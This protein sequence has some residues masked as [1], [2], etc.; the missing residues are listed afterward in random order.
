MSSLNGWLARLTA[1]L[2]LFVSAVVVRALP[3]PTVITEKT[4]IQPFGNDAHY[5]LRRIQYAALNPGDFLSRDSYVNFPYG[6]TPI[7]PPTFDW[8]LARLVQLTTGAGDQAAM[9]RLLVCV[10]P[11]L[12]G[13]TVVALYWIA[14][15]HFSSAVARHR[16]FRL[17][18]PPVFQ[19]S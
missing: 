17:V 10:P 4:G 13:C 12:G 1:P 5:H 11:V 9:E 16:V 15:R 18:L 6:G 19:V 7:W 8:T 14:R 2:R 3:W